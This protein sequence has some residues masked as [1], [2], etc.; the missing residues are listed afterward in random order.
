MS[1]PTASPAEV[2]E[3]PPAA[4]ASAR[5]VLGGGIAVGLAAVATAT[6]AGLLLAAALHLLGVVDTSPWTVGPWLAGAGLLGGWH[7]EV[8]ADVAGGLAWST[9]ASGAPLLA[10]VVAVW[11]TGSLVRR[12]RLPVASVP[13]AMVAAG[14]SAYVLVLASDRTTRTVDE[15]GTVTV[16]ESLTTWWT[17][18]WHPG[19]I[20][21]AALL[22]GVTGLV[23]TIGSTW[24]RAGR[25]VAFGLLVVPGVLIT[26]AAAAGVW[27]LTSSASLA[28]AV[29]LL[30]PLLGTTLLMAAGG[31]PADVGLTRVSPEPYD[32]STWTTGWLAVLAGVALC[33]V[34]SVLVGLV[35]RR[36][37]HDGSVLA[38]V[39]VTA[40]LAVFIT[41]AMVTTVVVP[42]SLGGVTVVATMPL[43]AGVVGAAMA[44]L[45]LLVR[46]GSR[47]LEGP[48]ATDS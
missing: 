14:V 7:Q 12:L 27:W 9:W 40:G 33:A 26:L 15:A 23:A 2:D 28:S 29:V 36:L 1:A 48:G 11:V 45:A 22:V 10:T 37:R 19:T 25:A 4:Q 13:V 42:P 30:A 24:W 43:A 34:V 44:A 20:T 16:Q 21:G 46:G 47:G 6:V 5:R 8:T 39:T 35:L 31:A 32:L 41:A 17:G 3:R 38:G 18:A